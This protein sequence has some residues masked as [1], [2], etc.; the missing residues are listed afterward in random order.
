MLTLGMDTIIL[1]DTDTMDTPTVTTVTTT[2]TTWAR[3][4]LMP[5]PL[6]L[7]MPP[8]RLMPLLMLGTDTMDILTP[9]TDIT[10]T[11]TPGLITTLERD[12]LM[13]N[14][15]PTLRPT[16]KLTLNPGMATTDIPTTED[17]TDTLM[18][19][20]FMVRHFFPKFPAIFDSLL[21]FR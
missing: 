4:L 1:T 10:D 5:N 14:P 18:D 19:T 8:L 12:L 9:T 17:I 6:L 11:P 20:A 15:R 7:L 2:V 21:S 3:G 16:L 13:P